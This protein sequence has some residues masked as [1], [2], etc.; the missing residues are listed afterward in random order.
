M[1]KTKYRNNKASIYKKKNYMIGGGTV[2]VQMD[3]KNQNLLD[4]II[5]FALKSNQPIPAIIQMLNAQPTKQQEMLDLIANAILNSIDGSHRVEVNKKI[6]DCNGI[7]QTSFEEMKKALSSFETDCNLLTEGGPIDKLS[8]EA[9]KLEAKLKDLPAGIFEL[10]LFSKKDDT[11][12]YTLDDTTPKTGKFMLYGVSEI[13]NKFKLTMKDILFYLFDNTKLLAI[14][15]TNSKFV[16]T[17]SKDQIT[18]FNGYKIPD[19]IDE[20]V[21]LKDTSS[22]TNKLYNESFPTFAKAP[23][24]KYFEYLKKDFD[25]NYNTMRNVINILKIFFD[26]KAD[27][28]GNIDNLDFS[29]NVDE[30]TESTRGSKKIYTFNESKSIP[31]LNFT[32]FENKIISSKSSDIDSSGSSNTNP[33]G[34]PDKPTE[35]EHPNITSYKDLI[36]EVSNILPPDLQNPSE[37]AV[38]FNTLSSAIDYLDENYDGFGS[39]IKAIIEKEDVFTKLDNVKENISDFQ[40]TFKDIT[41]KIFQ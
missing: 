39:D 33:D 3:T 27:S 16:L 28:A 31:L 22:F 35:P 23:T 15:Y 7:I 19:D 1:Y 34:I 13:F 12:E 40:K 2:T 14:D 41:G 26:V 9:K 36:K 4:C 29:F 8:E 32:T 20:S 24:K 30:V 37:N 21:D 11:M 38:V 17:A 18:T 5:D 6:V 25:T 10:R